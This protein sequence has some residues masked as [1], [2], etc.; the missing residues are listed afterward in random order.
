MWAPPIIYRAAY[1]LAAIPAEIVDLDHRDQRLR[2][3]S[4][5]EQ[6]FVRWLVHRGLQHT[7]LVGAFKLACVIDVGQE[8][9]VVKRSFRR[10]D[11]QDLRA[12]YDLVQHGLGD[13][14][15]QTIYVGY[16]TM[17]QE[18][19][20]PDERKFKTHRAWI[21][22]LCAHAHI[23]DASNNNVGWRGE[24]PVFFDLSMYVTS[25]TWQRSFLYGV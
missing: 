15:P 8:S 17:I 13:H 5:I 7:A 12:M 6:V 19:C 23:G 20:P 10:S 1:A 3:F 11:I 22:Y 2:E 14:I 18:C 21:R 16:G 25:P 4:R 9:W 24:V